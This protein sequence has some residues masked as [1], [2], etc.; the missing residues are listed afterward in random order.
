MIDPGIRGKVALVTG[1]NHG[2]GAATAK[3]LAA[4]GAKVFIA[5]YRAEPPYS[6]DELRAA[7]QAGTGGDRLY[8]AQQQ[9]TAERLIAEIE[10]AGGAAAALELDLSAPEAAVQL[11]DRCAA[12]LG[13]V[14]I[15]VNNHAHCALETFDPATVESNPAHSSVRLVSA[16]GIDRHMAVN[17]RATVLL[18]QEYAHRH[19]DRRATIAA[20]LGRCRAGLTR[21]PQDRRRLD[22]RPRAGRRPG[23]GAPRRG[24]RPP[25][26]AR[27]RDGRRRRAGGGAR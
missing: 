10:S 3:A 25:P 27:G 11:L 1:A 13:P 22:A 21:R 8:R 9:Q 19:I 24:R 26:T 17:V 2:I 4:Q 16:A 7:A 6:A 12:E 14:D 18:L 23:R 20:G 5:Y 15:L